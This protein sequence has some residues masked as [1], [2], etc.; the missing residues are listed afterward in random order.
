MISTLGPWS[1]AGKNMSLAPVV[2][3]STAWELANRTVYVPIQ[4]PTTITVTRVWWVNGATAT[5][6]ATVQC[7]LYTN[8]GGS[9]PQPGSKILSGS[10]TQATANVVQ[11]VNLSPTVNLSP[12]IYWIAFT[13]STTTNTTFFQNTQVAGMVPMVRMEEANAMP[14]T[15]TPV[16]SGTVRCWNCG[17]STNTDT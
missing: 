1:V 16:V 11:F 10:A 14:S 13:A 3:A 4:I 17:I 2:S 5:G 8:K 12:G 6:S 15:A 7:G 9:N